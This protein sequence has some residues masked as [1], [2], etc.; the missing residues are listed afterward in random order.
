MF[1]SIKRLA[2]TPK[3]MWLSMTVDDIQVTRKND[4]KQQFIQFTYTRGKLTDS[5]KQYKIKENKIPI[6]E[7][8][9]KKTTVHLKNEEIQPKYITIAIKVRDDVPTGNA[10]SGWRIVA[11]QQMEIGQYATP[12]KMGNAQKL[13]IKM[14]LSSTYDFTNINVR[15]MFR[16]AKYDKYD[17]MMQ[18]SSVMSS[19]INQSSI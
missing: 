10:N 19:S 15:L 9:S 2:Q 14:P 3:D 12:K 11:T 8:F 4:K 13:L 7:T 5:S 16:M 17:P 1:K 6:D 18:S